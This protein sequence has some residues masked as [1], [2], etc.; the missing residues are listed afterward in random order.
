MHAADVIKKQDSS[1]PIEYGDFTLFL[2]PGDE[3]F[4]SGIKLMYSPK[5]KVQYV[6][7][8]S[9]HAG[10]CQELFNRD[11]SPKC[12]EA[13]AKIKTTFGK[14]EYDTLYKVNDLTAEKVTI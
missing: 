13:I 8:N 7:W 11:F 14:L 12:F 9:E 5:D 3:M 1:K 6:E 10:P 4:F 2:G